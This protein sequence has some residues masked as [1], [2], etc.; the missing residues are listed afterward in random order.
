MIVYDCGQR[1]DEWLH[2][3][4][5]KVT[6]TRLKSLM[7]KDWLSVVDEVVAEI[8]TGMSDEPYIN[9]AMQWGIDNEPLAKNEYEVI[10]FNTVTECGFCLSSEFNRLGLSPD[11]WVGS[12]GAI[13]IKCPSSKTHIKYIRQD[14]IP[15]E[16]IWQVSNYFV[17]NEDLEWLDFV[18]Y[19]PRNVYY[20]IWI[21]R[22][23]REELDK[24]ITQ[25]R[26]IMLKFIPELD[27]QLKKIGILT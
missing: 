20:P 10:T 21:K 26:D 27:K 23:A 2:L 13:E 25:I 15:T 9:S 4:L 19:D 5:G 8:S 22:V 12:G 6:G 14:K 3:R 7:G 18:S 17:V 1:S 24:E 11:G 16:Y